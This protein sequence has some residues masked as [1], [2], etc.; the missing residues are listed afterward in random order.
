MKSTIGFFLQT[1]CLAALA[2]GCG[3]GTIDKATRPLSLEAIFAPVKVG[4]PPENAFHGLVQLPDDELRHYGFRGPQSSPAEHY[5]IFS[6]D[7]GLT[8]DEQGKT[9]VGD[10]GTSESGPPPARSPYS[11][12]WIRL[13]SGR[14]GTYC[15]RSESGIDGEYQRV[16]VSDERFGMVR[17]PVFLRSRQRAL[18]TT[19][20]S[21]GQGEQEVLVACAL[22]SDDDGLTWRIGR[23]PQGPRF[24]AVWPHEKV[25][26]QNY[27]IE[28][29][30]AEL[31]DG[32]IWMLLRT[33]M[34]NLYESFSTDG[35]ATWT[36]PVPSRFYATL[37]MPTFFRLTDGRLLLFWCNTTPLAE[38][39]RSTDMTIRPEQRNGLWEDVFTNRDA[40]HAA[41]SEDD[42]QSWIGFRELYLDPLRN[43]ADFA[44]RGGTEVSLDKSVHQSQAVELPQGK[45]LV[46]L[47]QHPLVR[48]LVIFDPAWLYETERGDSFTEGTRDWSTHKYMQGIKGHCAFDRDPG[49]PLVDHPDKAGRKA[50]HVHRPANPDLVCEKD[51]AVWNFPAGSKGSFTTRIRLEPGGSGGRICLVDRWFNP[52]DT[53]AY[54]YAMYSLTFAGDG[55]L[56]GEPLLEPGKWQELRFTWED[57]QSGSCSLYIDGKPY[58]HPLRLDRPSSNGICYVHFQS[59]ADREDPAGFLIESVKSRVWR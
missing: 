37:T 44:T 17:Q 9:V 10:A 50:L 52:T 8:W 54:R 35:G 23:V 6:R 49:A 30:V 31:A 15:L 25:R 5:Y 47:G 33:S 4:T 3:G 55:S 59:T 11:G 2:I 14:D 56:G 16:K 21:R 36:A 51:G 53:L 26:W 48:S 41:I 20:Q 12:T 13:V 39:D 1:C 40:I 43:E 57:S 7:N 38:V 22:C 18:I 34:D 46:A 29:T 27:A 45:V 42:G 32:T 58:T 24:E 28:P 19:G